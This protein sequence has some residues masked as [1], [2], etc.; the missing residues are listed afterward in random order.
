MLIGLTVLKFTN[1]LKIKIM[2]IFRFI[3]YTKNNNFLE[4]DVYR[5]PNTYG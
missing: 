1:D 5:K 4:F 3:S 2:S